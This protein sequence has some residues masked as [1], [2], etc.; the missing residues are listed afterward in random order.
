MPAAKRPLTQRELRKQ[1]EKKLGVHE[2]DITIYN[3]SRSRMI[4]VQVRDPESD[5]YIGE[6]TVHIHPGKRYTNKESRFNQAQLK[7]LQSK[8]ELRIIN[9]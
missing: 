4:S 5:F 1:K 9:G 7:N 2:N 3:P 8:G 6:Q